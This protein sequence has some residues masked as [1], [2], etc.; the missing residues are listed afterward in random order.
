MLMAIFS[1][2][3]RKGAQ[4]PMGLVRAQCSLVPLVLG[5]YLQC[6]AAHERRGPGIVA[7][8][9]E[10]ALSALQFVRLDSSR[11]PV[12]GR[13]GLVDTCFGRARAIPAAV[14]P[15]YV[16]TPIEEILA[17]RLTSPAFDLVGI[18]ERIPIEGFDLDIA[19]RVLPPGS[20]CSWGAAQ[21]TESALD[22]E[23]PPGTWSGQKGPV[24]R[25][26]HVLRHASS[27]SFEP[28]ALVA[29]GDSRGTTYICES[30]C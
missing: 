29:G 21:Q 18:G 20:G 5:A 28:T 9:G 17:A 22:C 14:E 12:R 15:S 3:G 8:A 30:L 1:G 24:A 10:S 27:I 19:P 16:S 7:D 4:G 23:S 6:G 25:D 11:A 2:C 26:Q 13:H